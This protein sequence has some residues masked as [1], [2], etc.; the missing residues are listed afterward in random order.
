[1][2][3]HRSP[4]PPARFLRRWCILLSVASLLLCQP[5]GGQVYE[6]VV[7]LT[8]L[9][10]AD[11]VNKG[12]TPYEALAQ[13]LDGNFFGT[14]RSGGA[15][16]FGTVFKMTPVGVLTTL[17]EFTENG[18]SN[19]GREPYA[20]LVRGSDGIFYGTTSSGGATGNGTVFKVTTAGVLTTL[21]AF[22]DNG[23]SNKGALPYAGLVE[24]SDGNFYGTTRF[25][26]A[27]GNG[28]VFAVTPAGVLTTLVEFSRNGATNKGAQ[29]YARMLRGSD[30]HFY[31][32][33]FFGGTND[34]GTVFKMTPAGV[35]TTLVEFTGDGAMNKGSGPSAGLIEGSDGSLYGTTQSGGANSN[36][37]VFKMTP[38]GVLTTL[39]EF[40]GNGAMN[41]G[42]SPRAALVQGSD[43]SFF[44]TTYDG[45]TNTFGTVFKM[46]PAGG[47]TTLAEFT[48][49]G[50]SNKGRGPYAGLAQGTDGNLY[51]TT[52]LGG[53]NN[54]GTIFQM[55]PAGEM[56]TL[57]EFSG[58]G[59]S[60]KGISPQSAMVEGSD[61]NFF[62]TTQSGGLNNNGTV[63]K[64]TPAGVLTT[65]AEFT[66][67]GVSNRGRYPQASLVKGSDSN[68]YGTTRFG[69]ADDIGTVF[70]LTQEGVLT[71]LVEFTG[72]GAT[73]KGSNPVTPLVQGSDGNFYGATAVGGA[74]NSGTIFKMTQVGALT[75]LVEFTSNGTT[76]KGRSP[77]AA[78][79]QTSDGSFYGTTAA[80]GANDAGTVFKMTPTG[81]LT[82][83]VQFTDNGASNKGKAPV[84]AL[85]LA[86]GGSFYGTTALG[87]TNGFGT[88]FKVTPDGI[89]T[90]LVHF[91]NN[92]ASNKGR[93]PYA[94]L[95]QGSDGNFYGTTS[96]KDAFNQFVDPGTVFKMTPAGV[97][98]TIREFP[99]G[100][101]ASPKASLIA[102]AD[103]NLY[104]TTEGPDGSVYRLILPGPPTA[105][106]TNL[107]FRG[108]T[109]ASVEA[110]V[111]ARGTST[112]AS[113]EY[114]LD[115]VSFPTTV[116]LGSGLSGFQTSLVGATFVGLNPG[117]TYF[118]RLRAVS[119]A[120]TT[121][122][123]VAS[124]S[125]LAEATV[126]AL[127]ASDV[128]PTSVRFNGTVNA[129]NFDSSVVF[130]WGT[131]GNSFPNT[132]PAT[133]GTVTGNADV[134]VS[135]AVAGL[136]KGQTYFYR[137][138]ATNA[139]GTVV[140][141]AA[142]FITL[143]EP[144]LVSLANATGVTTGSASVAGVVNAR[145]SDTT[146]AFEYGTDGVTF[147]N[148]ASA[149]PVATG[150]GD[151]TVSA[152]LA[153]LAEG[154]TYFYRLSATS[155]GGSATPSTPKRFTTLALPAVSGLGFSNVGSQ[156]ATLGAQVDARGLAT[157]VVFEYGPSAASFPFSVVATPGTVSGVA[158]VSA[159][160]TGLAPQTTYY[161]RVRA[162]SSAGT[163]IFG[164]QNFPTTASALAVTGSGSAALGVAS[165]IGTFN[166]TVNGFGQTTTVVFDYGTDAQ[167]L[168]LSAA[169]SPS[170]V[171]GTGNAQVSAT[172]TL[173]AG[174]T[175]YF[176][177]RAGN[178]AGGALGEVSLPVVAPT[179]GALAAL[180][181]FIF[182]SG[183][184]LIDPLRNDDDPDAVPPG[185]KSRL[186]LDPVL[187]QAPTVSVNVA[188]VSNTRK[189]I[190]YS[191]QFNVKDVDTLVY[192]VSDG[193]GGEATPTVN[194]ITF[195]SRAGFYS[196]AVA[197]AL[198]APGRTGALSLQMGGGG[199]IST[200]FANWR[201]ESYRLKGVFDQFGELTA[202]FTSSDDP[203]VTLT[204]ALTLG[205]TSKVI[206]GSLIE[207][208]DGTE[209]AR[210]PAF[211][212]T[213]NAG[214]GGLPEAG[215]R[216]AFL[217]PPAALAAQMGDGYV[218][219]TVARN[220][221]SA[222]FAG[223][224]PDG[225]P[226]LI[227][228]PAQ[229]RSFSLSK[230][231]EQ[232]GVLTGLVRVVGSESD[233]AGMMANL[234][235]RK[236][237][238]TRARY[239]RGGV[240][241]ILELLGMEYRPATD[242]RPPL[243]LGATS[244]NAR[245]SVSGGDLASTLDFPLNLLPTGVSGFD[246][247]KLKLK[248][249]PP[250]GTFSGSFVHPTTNKSVPFRG[251][252][253]TPLDTEPGQGRGNFRVP[254]ASGSVR[255]TAP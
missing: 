213:L 204:L 130:E 208:T 78:L 40:T 89:L 8:E 125:T 245:L 187:V 72:N 211:T 144:V 54:N 59:V 127:A 45:G 83:L 68:F 230:N 242:G 193:F 98:T 188:T 123:P 20:G 191:P 67:N 232:S 200:A 96:G 240:D 77:S 81:A 27:S 74:N 170:T 62:G 247:S 65:L 146:A 182:Y 180:D 15:S 214:T 153:G 126:N 156:T 13:G 120:G 255:I 117:T 203:R 183:A 152:T 47:L 137:I 179:K 166:G 105:L 71:T 95:V 209:T 165:V 161:F 131:D 113:L 250:L 35:L 6:K 108:A 75:T 143:T 248:L 134:A 158:A 162:V 26:G 33:T 174:Q 14:T 132:A 157:D 135:A 9:R 190:S 218:L 24:G 138:T 53:G 1:M 48:G 227:S 34:A 169:A 217:T 97:L 150:T 104:G 220:R 32:T 84:A 55:S 92:G 173:T 222:R 136:V 114:G 149:T 139:A 116:P 202:I 212:L 241:T 43:G 91:T 206:T 235:W 10:E 122:S 133:P 52:Q 93:S 145:G 23:A 94:G 228:A 124:F 192:R 155:P 101:A 177:V 168:N 238:S 80:G 85:V 82:T 251:A 128:A 64:M 215:L 239:H 103:E 29:P 129:R 201:S 111:N 118:C 195:G 36:G 28:T 151:T 119:S 7:D 4:S 88:V 3:N 70:K 167:N 216:T 164:P 22:T 221:R 57:V 160:L 233:D 99:V 223:Q 50:A 76:N 60:D 73:N 109:T 142:S 253:R 38:A 196:G 229:G 197:D 163:T 207:R 185:D 154:T 234:L 56:T 5:C 171:S 199:T 63:F 90:T 49:S 30:G 86:S 194:L 244:P 184:I 181:D 140:S 11:S 39:V 172:V 61:G 100:S 246:A 46:T 219:M 2:N 243:E 249:Q 16:G 42:R 147:P 148:S 106:L 176:R 66:G 25:G 236:R 121:F 254:G 69:G 189:T 58:N 21:V 237:T 41:K 44:G 12:R 141:G 110:Q 178:G 19:K 210:V 224:L 18:T 231:L 186:L 37:T 102:A 225:E 87:G 175:Y 226:F 107:K 31:G 51:G 159:Q 17:V 205:R 112:A 252:F 198:N 115:G 79:I